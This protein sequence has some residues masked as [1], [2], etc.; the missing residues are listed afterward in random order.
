LTKSIDVFKLRYL[1]NYNLGCTYANGIVVLDEDL[2]VFRPQYLINCNCGCAYNNRI[3]VLAEDLDTFG[4][5]VV[6]AGGRMLPSGN[7]SF[8]K[9]TL[10]GW[11]SGV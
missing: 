7:L 10:V 11:M 1:I 3:V 9:R 2:D 5:R 6:A 4:L 8:T